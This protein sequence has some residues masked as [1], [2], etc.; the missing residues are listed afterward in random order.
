MSDFKVGDLALAI[1]LKV[2]SQFN[3]KTGKI[4]TTVSDGKNEVRWLPFDLSPVNDDMRKLIIAH[5][6]IGTKTS[7][8]KKL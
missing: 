8:L 7:R 3:G 1:D 6:G 2:F 4:T 5:K